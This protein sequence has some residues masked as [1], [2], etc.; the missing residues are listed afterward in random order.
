VATRCA[1]AG[2]LKLPP[3]PRLTVE[4]LQKPQGERNEDYGFQ[5]KWHLQV[6]NDQE[7][8]L[9]VERLKDHAYDCVA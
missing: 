4:H 7:S 8:H 6:P 2:K 1:R 9:D 3:F 5:A